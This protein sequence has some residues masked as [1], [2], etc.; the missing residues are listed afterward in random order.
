MSEVTS[1]KASTEVGSESDNE[2][3]WPWSRGMEHCFDSCVFIPLEM[4]GLHGGVVI[5]CEGMD[6]VSGDGDCDDSDF[7]LTSHFVLC[8]CEEPLP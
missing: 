2:V 8:N 5:D 3:E 6:E 4:D 7:E 1:S